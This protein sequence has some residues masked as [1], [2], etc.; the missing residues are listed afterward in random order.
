M[1][2]SRQSLDNAVPTGRALVDELAQ[3]I[4]SRV[5]T[6]DFPIGSWLRQESL[7][8]EFGVSRTPIREALRKLQA[9]GTVSLVPHRG[10]LVRG[11]TAREI[12]EA[13]LVRAELE[14]LA[15]ELAA[16]WISD[17]QL[18]RLRKAEDLFRRAVKDFVARRKRD[19]HRSAAEAEW[20]RANDLFHDVVQEAADNVR[21]TQTILDLHRTFPRNL[22]WAALS[23][24]SRLLDENARQ[25]LQILEAIERRDALEARRSMTGHIRR[26]G[27]LVGLWFER[28]GS[29][30]E[31]DAAAT[32]GV[33][34]SI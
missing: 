23:E 16:N 9:N 32:A 14:G 22:T 17:E 20:P 28:H 7:A 25:H 10:A 24:D 3:K 12:R 8:S 11:P 18:K 30:P 2:V 21:L 29:A 31:A 6:G 15:A 26:S 19:S 27:E 34:G 33:I 4:Q 5:L 1:T 13:Y